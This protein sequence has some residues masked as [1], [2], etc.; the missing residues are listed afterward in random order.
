MANTESEAIASNDERK[1]LYL[2]GIHVTHS[3]APPMHNYIASSL[4]LPWKFISQECPRVEDVLSIFRARTF[5]GG[6][7]TM[8]YKKA[9][10]PLLDE[11]D[12]LA[13]TLGACNNVYLTSEGKLRGTNTD[14]RGIK[15]C[16]LSKT[17][18]GGNDGR[19]YPALIIGA[20]G[21]SRAAVYALF[22]ELECAAIYVVNR[23]AQEVADLL[24]DTTAYTSSS[25]SRQPQLIHVTSVSQAEALP[26]A[27]YVVGT[28]PDFEAKT[29]E[30][31]TARGILKTFLAKEQKGV[32]LDMC[33]KPRN[34][35]ILKLGKEE[36]W[37]VIDGTGVIGHQIEEQWRLWANAGVG[38][39]EEVPK[40]EAWEVLR[41]AADE[42]K[43]INF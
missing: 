42:S 36:G 24:Q 30:E 20:G 17:K 34:T 19:G 8:P 40:E 1:Y 22:A 5:A 21:A 43:A 18:D 31:I 10:M 26:A 37:R 33:F 25:S 39:M 3:I 28:V 32:L 16:L 35:R 29:K 4:S 6:V 13:T 38:R 7:V 41:K 15:G 11:L 27:F 9:I 23:D 12:P 14:W 2:A